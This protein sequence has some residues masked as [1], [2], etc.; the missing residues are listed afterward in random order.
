MEPVLF[1]TLL[2]ILVSTT[3]NN[4]ATQTP[5][6]S[7]EGSNQGVSTVTLVSPVDAPTAPIT[8][9]QD[10]GSGRSIVAPEDNQEFWGAFSK[11]PWDVGWLVG[12]FM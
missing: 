6:D 2:D 4:Q 8:S 12:C 3:P 11:L 10:N 5:P 9:S 7:S 1:S